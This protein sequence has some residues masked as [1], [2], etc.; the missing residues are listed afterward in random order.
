MKEKDKTVS[1]LKTFNKKE[2]IL[3]TSKNKT[4]TPTTKQMKKNQDKE[5]QHGH[6]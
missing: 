6:K 2:I 5:I 1:L 4:E 3:K